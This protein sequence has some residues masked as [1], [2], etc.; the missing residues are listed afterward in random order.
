MGAGRSLVEL[1]ASWLV[2]RRSL[3]RRLTSI[4]VM[5]AV[6][7]DVRSKRKQGGQGIRR[8]GVYIWIGVNSSAQTSQFV[9]IP[10]TVS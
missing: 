8:P 5:Y 10:S 2:A 6:K 4:T 7:G 9:L 1:L 3:T